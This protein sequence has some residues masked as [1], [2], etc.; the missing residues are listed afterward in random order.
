[1]ETMAIAF[2][3]T[4]TEGCCEFHGKQRRRMKKYCETL[5]A[6]MQLPAM[7]VKRKLRFS[8]T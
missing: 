3:T 7:L 5:K 1:V 8:A 2:E 4:G 6:D